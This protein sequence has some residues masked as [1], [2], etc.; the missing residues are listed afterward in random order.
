M[1]SKKTTYIL[2]VVTAILWGIIIYR[3]FSY[4]KKDMAVS[5]NS[6]K[7]DSM[8]QADTFDM[9]LKLDYQDPFLPTK[10]KQEISELE[11]RPER[12]ISMSVSEPPT[13]KYRGMIRNKKGVYA[14]IEVEGIVETIS[15][16]EPVDGFQ[17]LAMN[18]D[19]L[20]VGRCGQKY[21]L[22]AN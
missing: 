6:S 21:S 4:T 14:M 1:K 9:S 18:E 19:S 17:I 15:K 5:H 2:L 7:E 22:K 10:K 12:A 13:F 20:I 3:I 16:R 11:K 8:L